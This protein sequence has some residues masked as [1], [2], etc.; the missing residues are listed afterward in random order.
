MLER[1]DEDDRLLLLLGE[2]EVGLELLG[3]SGLP[4]LIAFSSIPIAIGFLILCIRSGSSPT[5]V[6]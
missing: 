3:Y 2:L 1:V 5:L 4:V 6:L